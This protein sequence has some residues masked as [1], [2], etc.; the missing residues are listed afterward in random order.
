MFFYRAA[1]A[2]LASGCLSAAIQPSFEPVG[3]SYVAVTGGQ[4]VRITH[5]E[6]GFGVEPAA[7]LQ[8]RG[9][10]AG[11]VDGLQS[12]AGVTNYYSGREQDG[13]WRAGVPHY[14]RVRA[15]TLYPRIDADYYFREN[16]LEFDL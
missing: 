4:P 10:R 1:L 8:W 12:N 11:I 7:V 2:C 3:N 15:R 5:K 14:A 13:G 6:V 9:A 16:R